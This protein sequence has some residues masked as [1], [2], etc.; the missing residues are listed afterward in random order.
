MTTSSIELAYQRCPVSADTET[1]NQLQNALRLYDQAA[2]QAAIDGL[3]KIGGAA[4]CLAIVERVLNPW[5]I[6]TIGRGITALPKLA[7]HGGLLGLTAALLV[8]S[9]F[10][11]AK[12]EALAKFCQQRQ[13]VP[14]ESW[15]AGV[16]QPIPHWR[17]KQE[18]PAR[19]DLLA[20]ATVTDISYGAV[21]ATRVRPLP[22]WAVNIA[23]PSNE[24]VYR[25]VAHAD[26]RVPG[27]VDLLEHCNAL[28]L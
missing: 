5:G 21:L 11:D 14:D 12:L 16:A 17:I 18:I 1:V 23:M 22:Q 3:V 24:Q 25:A 19:L 13:D 9:R 28:D 20:C 10:L 26:G 27:L 15:V 7:A 8:D 4:A 6:T 2:N